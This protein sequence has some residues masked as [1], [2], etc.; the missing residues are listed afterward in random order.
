M[1]R[2][3][4]W[5]ITLVVLCVALLIGA[6]IFVASGRKAD[7]D[8][9][10]ARRT[11]SQLDGQR[12]TLARTASADTARVRQISAAE[13]GLSNATQK[14]A[15]ALDSVTEAQSHLVDVGN[16]AVDLYN[17]GRL[18]DSVAELKGQGDAA[19][20][21][22]EARAAVLS[23]RMSSLRAAIAHLQEVVHG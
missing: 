13:L 22:L 18:S 23:R 1:S 5:N 6:G 14:V 19:E 16:Q 7:A 3:R 8:A 21:T 15:V 11:A 2:I 10:N 17:Q 12:A 4:P 9:A 20:S